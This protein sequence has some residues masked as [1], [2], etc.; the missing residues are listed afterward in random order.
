MVPFHAPGTVSNWSNERSMEAFAE[1]L[2]MRCWFFMA[3]L[4][5]LAEAATGHS[6]EASLR[7]EGREGRAKPR[8]GDRYGPDD[9]I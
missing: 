5:E 2:R 1:V 7:V 4:S 9:V 8:D 3:L 6:Q